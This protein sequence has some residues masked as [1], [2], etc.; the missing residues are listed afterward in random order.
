MLVARRSGPARRVRAEQ[1]RHGG[2]AGRRGAQHL[3]TQAYGVRTGVDEGRD[4]LVGEPALGARRRRAPCRPPARRGRPATPSPPRGARPPGRPPRR[5]RRR[6]R[7]TRGRPPRGTTRAWPAWPPPER[8]PA[9]SRPT[10]G[11][12]RPSR[13]RRTGRRPRHDRGDAHLGEHL[14]G[15]LAAVA[16]RQRLHHHDPGRGLVVL[17]APTRPPPRRRACPSSTP[18]PPPTGRA[19]R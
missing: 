15:E 1:R 2:D 19:R 12:R 13:P 9:T 4:L 8:W 7:S 14:D 17:S 11:P 16:L 6:R 3:G 18:R 5:G 10:S